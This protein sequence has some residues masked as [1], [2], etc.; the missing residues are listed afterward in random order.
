[1]SYSKPSPIACFKFCAKFPGCM[2]IFYR[3]LS[4]GTNLNAVNFLNCMRLHSAFKHDKFA[5][6]AAICIANHV[7]YLL[8]QTLNCVNFTPWNNQYMFW[9]V[10]TRIF[11]ALSDYELDTWHTAKF[12]ERLLPLYY[13]TN[14]NRCRTDRRPKVSSLCTRGCQF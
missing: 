13:N 4:D 3:V 11:I 6:D 8:I 7:L 5:K 1:M 10:T 12:F 9:I 2:T 14:C